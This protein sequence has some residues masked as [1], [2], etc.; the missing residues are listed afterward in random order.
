MV[1]ILHQTIVVYKDR[2]YIFLLTDSNKKIIVK[3]RYNY[4]G[5]YIQYKHHTNILKEYHE[6][7]T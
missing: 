6:N 3:K 1:K 5:D 2:R 4:V 7:N